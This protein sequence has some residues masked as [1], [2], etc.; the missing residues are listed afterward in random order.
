MPPAFEFAPM[1][2]A[3][4]PQVMEIERLSF[5]SDPWTPGLFLHE[6][7]LDFSRLHLAR[8]ADAPRRVVGYACW[9][10]VGDEVHILNLAVRPEARGSGAGRALVQRILD[11]AVAHGAVSVSLEVRP[12]NAAALGLYRAMG[13][14]Q[15][16]RRKNYYG[17]GEDAVIMERRFD[18]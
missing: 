10:L 6:L 15:I 11:D 1:V 7:K 17:R 9:W 2:A 8:T 5:A 3:D 12:E 4:L 16:G 18:G 13:F 14:T